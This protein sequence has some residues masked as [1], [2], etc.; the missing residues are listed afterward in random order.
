MT[1]ATEK[2]QERDEARR[3]AELARADEL[4]HRSYVRV[5]TGTGNAV[6]RAATQKLADVLRRTA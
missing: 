1:T 4:A 3:Q 2:R 5:I 6:E